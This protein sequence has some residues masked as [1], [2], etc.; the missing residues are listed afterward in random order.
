MTKP[1]KG[2][3]ITLNTSSDRYHSL[4]RMGMQFRR[5][6]LIR[7]HQVSPFGLAR[8]SSGDKELQD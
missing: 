7:G 4:A 3:C 5:R 6:G 2:L 1:S 8:V